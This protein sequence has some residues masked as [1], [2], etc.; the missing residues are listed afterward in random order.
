MKTTQMASDR[1]HHNLPQCSSHCL[2]ACMF[3]LIH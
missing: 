1:E 3:Q 2:H